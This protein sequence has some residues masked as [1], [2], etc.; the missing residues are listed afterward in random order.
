[1]TE[2]FGTAGGGL[3]RANASVH[4]AARP[5]IRGINPIGVSPDRGV[6]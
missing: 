1:M 6:K 3:V 5:R 4:D 2:L